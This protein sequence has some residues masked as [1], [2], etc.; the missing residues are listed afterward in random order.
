MC[1]DHLPTSPDMLHWIIGK[2]EGPPSKSCFLFCTGGLNWK[3]PWTKESYVFHN[4]HND[5]A[6]LCWNFDFPFERVFFV[7]GPGF[8]FFFKWVVQPPQGQRTYALP[9]VCRATKCFWRD[10]R[11]PLF[12]T[13]SLRQLLYQQLTTSPWSRKTWASPIAFYLMT[14]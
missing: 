11:L 3:S 4:H 10:V 2:S 1:R 5:K 7:G 6:W 13:D 9:S 12:N 14:S 8:C